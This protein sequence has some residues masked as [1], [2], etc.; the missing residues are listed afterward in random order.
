MYLLTRSKLT[1]KRGKVLIKNKHEALGAVRVLRTGATSPR[2][3]RAGAGAPS[4]R[5][6]AHGDS[7]AGSPPGRAPEPARPPHSLPA[8]VLGTPRP[9][10]PR[11]WSHRPGDLMLP[12]DQW[13]TRGH[14]RDR[15]GRPTS[16]GVGGGASW[17]CQH[18]PNTGRGHLRSSA[19]GARSGCQSVEATLLRNWQ[20]HQQARD[21]GS[22]QPGQ[23]GDG[24]G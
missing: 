21:P 5:G 2:P 14:L 4:S 17:L 12:G 24:T 9:G 18:L 8:R 20:R 7:A 3:R 1:G 22:V 13:L 6:A 23:G 10:N 19:V 11:G 15:L 16:K